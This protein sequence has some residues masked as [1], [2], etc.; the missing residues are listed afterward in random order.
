MLGSGDEDKSKFMVFLLP[1]T[2]STNYMKRSGHGVWNSA[3]NVSS[4]NVRVKA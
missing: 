4:K 2:P 1:S 3:H